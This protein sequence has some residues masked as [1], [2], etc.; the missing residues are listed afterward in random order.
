MLNTTEY[1]E[2]KYVINVNIICMIYLYTLNK[3]AFILF[4]DDSS[5]GTLC[6]SNVY[7]VKNQLISRLINLIL[8]Y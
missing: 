3:I 5:I 1:Y 6:W 8:L 2:K 7:K 4:E